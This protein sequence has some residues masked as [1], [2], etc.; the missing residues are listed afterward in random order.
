[1]D[2]S[3]SSMPKENVKVQY[4]GGYDGVLGHK[5][6]KHN[7]IKEVS[8]SEADRLLLTGQF[9]IVKE[10]RRQKPKSIEK[11]KVTETVDTSEKLTE[12]KI[13]KTIDDKGGEDT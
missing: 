6:W 1:M 13:E 7:V 10:Q 5:L 2:R 8:A 3:V 9:K 12:L 11:T 4:I